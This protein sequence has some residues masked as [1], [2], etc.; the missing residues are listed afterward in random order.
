MEISNAS[1]WEAAIL[2]ATSGGD[3]MQ[4]QWVDFAGCPGYANQPIHFLRTYSCLT[5]I[6]FFSSECNAGKKIPGKGLC[7]SMCSIYAD[8]V[9]SLLKDEDVCTSGIF[10]SIIII[11]TPE[12]QT[13]SSRITAS[14]KSYPTEMR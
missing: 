9:D 6:F 2:D 7:D 3:L 1:Q 12:T 8:A 11:F 5:D 14:S 13:S 4:K 10:L